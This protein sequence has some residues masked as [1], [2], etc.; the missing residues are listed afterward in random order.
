MRIFIQSRVGD[1]SSPSPGPFFPKVAGLENW[2]MATCAKEKL[3]HPKLSNELNCRGTKAT[4]GFSGRDLPRFFFLEKNTSDVFFWTKG[5]KVKD[6][7]RF[8][9]SK[10]K[11]RWNNKSDSWKPT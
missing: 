10:L 2:N 1:F 9:F 8:F 5:G 6:N 4:N 3:L 11:K 7:P